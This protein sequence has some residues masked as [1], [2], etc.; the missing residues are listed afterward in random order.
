MY[1]N[2]MP[3]REKYRRGW[4]SPGNASEA[5]VWV[6]LRPGRKASKGKKELDPY[7]VLPFR[8]RKDF[9]QKMT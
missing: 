4:K 7:G 2:D 3:A 6:G 8:D 9:K 1:P 5:E